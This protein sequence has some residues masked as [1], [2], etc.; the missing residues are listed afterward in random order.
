MKY[1]NTEMLDFFW[2]APEK[3]LFDQNVIAVVTALSI[4][5]LQRARWA[6]FGGPSFIKIGRSVRYRKSDVLEFL[7][8]CKPFNSTTEAQHAKEALQ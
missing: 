7:E 1:T 8:A 2:S 4:S 3:A 5:S 6:G